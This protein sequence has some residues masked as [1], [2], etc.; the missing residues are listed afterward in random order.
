[1][2]KILYANELAQLT[3][4]LLTN[5]KSVVANIGESQQ[6]S[7]I[8]DIAEAIA[9]NFDGIVGGTQPADAPGENV[10]PELRYPCVS[11]NPDNNTEEAGIN[12]V[13]S[14][15]DVDGWEDETVQGVTSKQAKTLRHT[16]QEIIIKDIADTRL[17]ENTN[18][19]DADG[20]CQPLTARYISEVTVID[21]DTH[22]PVEV[23]MYKSDPNGGIFGIDCSFILTLSEE[24]PVSCPFSGKDI[25]LIEP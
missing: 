9:R 25:S 1:M 15:F 17:Y 11:I 23:A 6:Q 22:S 16:L 7:F 18:A 13:W 3:Y 12:S 24:D 8:F 19:L 10:T 20:E 4:T 21:P 5:P 2:A 14:A